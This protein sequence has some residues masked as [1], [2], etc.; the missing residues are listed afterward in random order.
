MAGTMNF[1]KFSF[2]NGANAAYIDD[3]YH[4]FRDNPESVEPSW[5]S[6]FEGYEFAGQGVAGRS[7]NDL[8]AKV[9]AY[10]NAFR[11]LGHLSAHLDPLNER[12]ALRRDLLPEQHG[13]G[14]VPKGMTFHPSNLPVKGPLT[15]E[16]IHQL[17]L[18][19]YTRT[20]GADYREINDIE[21]VIWFQEQMEG[22][23]NRPT[24]PTEVKRRIFGK[25]VE[26]EGFE[27]FLQDRYLGQKRFSA[28]GLESLIPLLDIMSDEAVK[29]GVEEISMGMAHRGR[30]NVL[31]NFMGKPYEMMFKEFEGSEYNTH[32]IDGDVKYHKGYASYV[33]TLSGQKVRVNLA[34]NPSHLEAVNPVVEGF[35]RA[36]QRLLGDS[37]F[38]RVMPVLLHGDASFVGQGI[39]AE[40]LNLS[41]L[42]A[43]QTGGTIHVITNN[44][45][46][47]T[48]NPDESRSCNYSSDIAKMVRAPV[49][50]VNA[51]DPEAVIWTARL[52]VA[53]RQ[54]FRKDIVIDLV[55]Y[56]RHGHNETDEPTF[57]QPQMYRIIKNHETVLGIY[58]S[59]LIREGVMTQ[60]ETDEEIKRFRT[61]L[62]TGLDK[63]RGN[64]NIE[65]LITFPKELEYSLKY[66]K[67]TEEDCLQKVKTAVNAEK[68]Q[69][70]ATSIA[71]VPAGFTPHPKIA[72]LFQTRVEMMQGEGA[73]DWGMAELLAYGTLAAEKHHVR[74]SGQDCR[75]GTFSH[76]HAVIRDYES[77][78]LWHALNQI[79]PD[80]APVD[81]INS[82]LSE[83]GVMG[84]EFGY[85]VADRDALVLW[86]AQFG[87][88]ANGGQIII[89]QFLVASEAKWKQ[90]CGLVLMLPHGYEGMGPE[91]S[92]ARPE[93]FLQLCGNLNIQVINPTTPAQLF[94]VLRRQMVRE[95]RKPL[96]LMTPKSLLRHAKVVS[97]TKEFSTG[98]FQEVMTDA[99]R[100]KSDVRRLLLCTGKVFY[101]LD[102]AREKSPNKGA[103]VGILRV[104]QMYPFPAKMLKDLLASYGNLEEVAW[105]QEEPMNMGAWAFMR[106][107]IHAVLPSKV[108]GVRY[109]G[110]K[111]AGTTAEGSGKSHALEQ[112]RIIREALGDVQVGAGSE[113]SAKRAKASK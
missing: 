31:T 62:Q 52:A 41:G 53:Y 1:Q 104:E 68:L 43:Y 91:H 30:L 37:G 10:I 59:Q 110:R 85:S 98:E 20:I 86:E 97:K 100:N 93:R 33:E 58:T 55:G 105:V 76:R 69:I 51:D 65:I 74:L 5:R 25:L 66:V 36:R 54:K 11:R 21:A 79:S 83:Q 64:Q 78:Q 12:P 50:H 103:E 7:G 18:D 2:A 40:T 108:N 67:A 107:K 82:P 71:T 109:I 60:A 113:K 111:N 32:D 87:D 38:Q 28:E 96:I 19:T 22:C 29:G 101:D 3:L 88:F 89:D 49:L 94:H 57:T 95:F 48:T 17:M 70:V 102:E 44:Q 47:F 77:G 73:I 106:D 15:F 8:E 16:E 99:D 45:V 84:F 34:P 46:G 112:D 56:R 81:V 27:R 61:R 23:R 35:T 9:E 90:A 92:S 14:D 26:A 63:V 42:E 75:R 13:L 72:K 80:Q 24:I 39:V 4:R 6:F